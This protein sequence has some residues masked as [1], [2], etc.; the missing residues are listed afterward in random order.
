MDGLFVRYAHY[1][2]AEPLVCTFLLVE[3]N[4]LYM[5]CWNWPLPKLCRSHAR[6]EMSSPEGTPT[7]STRWQSS[8]AH[9]CVSGE[10]RTQRA[11]SDDDHYNLSVQLKLKHGAQLQMNT[12]MQACCS[13]WATELKLAAQVSTRTHACC[14]R[15]RL[16]LKLAAQVSTTTQACCPNEH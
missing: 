7:G 13:I 11:P 2:I 8:R 4:V 14:S 3:Q 12:T 5:F 16:Q 9:G 1:H 10:Y 15:G 6:Y